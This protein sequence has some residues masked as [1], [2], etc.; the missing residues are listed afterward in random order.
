MG[1]ASAAEIMAELIKVVEPNV[2]DPAVRKKIY[3]PV[4]RAFSEQD[5][6]T[7]DACLGEDCAYDAALDALYPGRYEIPQPVS[8]A[9]AI[10]CD[11]LKTGE[12]LKKLGLKYATISPDLGIITG[13]AL[14]SRIN[15]FST[16]RGVDAV[17]PQQTVFTQE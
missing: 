11:V 5:W 7:Q 12:E 16:V 4:I 3:T 10:E 15:S 17:E 1:W 2:P 14:P 13:A 8:I 6:D 9:L